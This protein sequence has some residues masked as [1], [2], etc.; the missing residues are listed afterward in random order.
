MPNPGIAAA[1]LMAAA[2]IQTDAP[3]LAG[4]SGGDP[5]AFAKSMI[6][7]DAAAF[8]R[9]VPRKT[10][11]VFAAGCAGFVSP[12]LK[13]GRVIHAAVRAQGP[14]C[15]QLAID[16]LT[17]H[18]GAPMRG[19]YSYSDYIGGTMW[20]Y[21]VETLK[22]VEPDFDIILARFEGDSDGGAIYISGPGQLDPGS[23]KV[24]LPVPR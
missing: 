9:A 15:A 19:G 20:N 12:T 17:R 7:M 13:H 8:K 3:M 4:G 11:I 14:Q 2:L 22:W 23:G 16:I 18:Y 5:L 24:V 1:A 10:G 6:G 21:R